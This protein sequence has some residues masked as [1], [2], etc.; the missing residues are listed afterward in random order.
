M[1]DSASGGT[2]HQGEGR[3][4][5]TLPNDA[6]LSP[7]FGDP[8]G[9]LQ[10]AGVVC[11]ILV[12]FAPCFRLNGVHAQRCLIDLIIEARPLPMAM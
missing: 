5:A 3:M 4:G 11:P 1:V 12:K 8:L 9:A 7:C 2:G 6:G 10:V